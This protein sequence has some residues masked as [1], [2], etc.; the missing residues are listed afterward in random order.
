MTRSRRAFEV[1]FDGI[2]LMNRL[3][4]RENPLERNPARA[5]RELDPERWGS[6]AS[7]VMFRGLRKG[8]ST[9]LS[10]LSRAAGT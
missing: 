8:R 4:T 3:K 5:N 7:T 2:V 1:G 6:P 10:E 9:V